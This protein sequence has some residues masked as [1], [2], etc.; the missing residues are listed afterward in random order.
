MVRWRI[1]LVGGAPGQGDA[2]ADFDFHGVRQAL[3]DKNHVLV[4]G[5]QVLAGDHVLRQQADRQL[6]LRLDADDADAEGALAVGGQPAGGDAAR[7]RHDLRLG[8]G[9]LDH[10]LVVCQGQQGVQVGFIIVAGGVDL[11]IAAQDLDGVAINGLLEA[12]DQAVVH[13]HHRQGQPDGQDDDE[14]AAA[15]AP[16]IA[17]GQA[18][19]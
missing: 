3:T 8:Q 13:H 4:G 1:W 17:P 7:S 18:K 14:R 19:V 12:G 9:G 5:G 16:D 10:G 6:F 2:V 11:D 15:V